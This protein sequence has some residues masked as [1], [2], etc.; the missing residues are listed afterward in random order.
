MTS[1]P[2]AIVFKSCLPQP[3]NLYRGCC[4]RGL[5]GWSACLNHLVCAQFHNKKCF[6]TFN[7]MHHTKFV[8]VLYITI[9]PES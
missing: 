6:E 5:G 9:I 8:I 1:C 4:D 3:V 7:S 2:A